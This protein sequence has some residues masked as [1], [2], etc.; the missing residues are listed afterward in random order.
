MVSDVSYSDTEFGLDVQV[1]AKRGFDPK[2]SETG[3]EENKPQNSNLSS[4][5]P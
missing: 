2:S 5:L 4:Y 3:S 1:L